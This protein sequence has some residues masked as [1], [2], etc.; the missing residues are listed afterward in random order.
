MFES[1]YHADLSLA[2][3]K[4]VPDIS[5]ITPPDDNDGTF[6]VCFTHPLLQTPGGL[7]VRISPQEW[8]GYPSEHFLVA[9]LKKP[10]F[11]YP[12]REDKSC[13]PVSKHI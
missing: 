8:S 12:D 6:S 1:R 9:Q 4:G 10:E 5:H 13:L 7:E 3:E 2:I 11:V